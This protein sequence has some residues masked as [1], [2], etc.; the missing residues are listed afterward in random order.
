MLQT[1]KIEDFQVEVSN[2]HASHS[3]EEIGDFCDGTLF[4]WH[5]ILSTDPHALQV[6][7]NYDELEVVNLIGSYVN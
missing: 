6:V 1:K 7:A 3:D 5:P 4:K 2:S